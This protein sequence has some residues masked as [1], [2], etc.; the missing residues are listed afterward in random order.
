MAE[1]QVELRY[2]GETPIRVHLSGGSVKVA[3][4]TTFEVPA[5][6]AI[7]YLAASD[8]IRRVGGERVERQAADDSKG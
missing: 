4:G 1:K 2:D 6:D 7:A 8:G 3:P 5:V